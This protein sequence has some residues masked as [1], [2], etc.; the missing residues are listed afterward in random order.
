MGVSVAKQDAV[1]TNLVGQLKAKDEQGNVRDVT[2]GDLIKNGEQL[3]FSPSAQFILEM[4]DGTVVDETTISPDDPALPTS[5]EEGL[6]TAPVSTDAE[7]AALQAQILAGEDPTAGLPETAAGTAAGGGGNEG[8]D[9]VTL[10]RTADE[11]IAGSGHDTSGFDLTAAPADEEPIIPEE[12]ILPTLTS[13]S[14]TVSETNLPQG[15]APL[16]SALSQADTITLAAPNGISQVLINGVAVFTG[17]VFA[18]PIAI[19]SASGTLNIT[20]FDAATGILSYSYTLNSAVDHSAAEPQIDSFAVSLTDI[21]G[22]NTTS[23][24][25][26]NLLDDAPSGL[27]DSGNIGEDDVS[28]SGSVIDNDTQGAD[29]STVSLITNADGTSLAVAQATS[30]DGSFGAL[31]ISTDGS[32]SYLLSTQLDAVQ[33]LAQGEQV[34][35]SFTYQLTDSDG[36]SVPVTLTVTITGTNDAPVIITDNGI[37]G[38]DSGTVVEAGN[39]DDG[40][41]FIGTPSVSGTLAA[42]DIDNGA[43]LTWSIADGVGNLGSFS[44]DPD[45]GTWFY[46]LNNDLADGLAEGESAQELFNVT[47]TD[48]FGSTDTQV[49]IITVLGTNDS[50]ILTVDSS[51]SITE[52]D[53]NPTLTDNGTLSFSDVDISNTHSISFSY[54]SDIN[55][56]GGTLTPAQESALTTGFNAD[57]NNWDYSALNSEVQFLGAGETITM[58]FDVTVT[59]NDGASDTETVTITINGTNDAPVITTDD[60]I[61]GE[62]T[63][64]VVEAGNFDN[65]TPFSGTPSVSGTLA[66]DDVDNGAILTWSIANGVG[67]LG[68]FSID[69]DSGTWIYNLN[70]DLADGLA[71]GESAQDL[72]NVTVTDEFG[73]TDT[74]IVTI[75]V[76]GSNDSPILTVD[77]SGS[78]TEDDSNPT[79]TDS[80]FLSFSD[81]DI[82]NTHSISFS[83]NSDINWS[84]G[85]LT[86][87]QESALITG[88]S[89]DTNSWD[90]NAS[91]S[92]VQFLDAGETI[93]MSFNVTVTDNDGASDTETVTITINGINDAPE[94]TPDFG[95][96]DEDATLTVAA[97]NGVL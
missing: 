72:F 32:Y 10:D 66:A 24:I 3:I 96:V 63:G 29:S 67:N 21:L 31:Q 82:S 51:G 5:Q 15:S 14:I 88:F 76:I 28:V 85:I 33:S 79:L 12:N 48:E 26:A 62:D 69:P 27:D 18:G 73:S 42:N 41:P 46:T 17:G 65:G 91:N 89:A 61:D 56:S 58:S 11:T 47:V 70:N 30:I 59:D 93:T 53:S 7:I 94:L 71:E 8:T 39:L 57:T 86:P 95:E 44:I 23:T 16:A 52:D 19:T 75:T 25:T 34:T 43:I 4:A 97:I 6:A 37:D 80:G 2:I 81:V 36:D 40:T 60:G 87:A 13:S 9:F 74:Q 1:V 55:W 84:G 50:P 38:E 20:G 35:D 68:N 77:S 22:N 45:S 54:N 92:D 83:Y 78:V 64:T 49:V 90:Y